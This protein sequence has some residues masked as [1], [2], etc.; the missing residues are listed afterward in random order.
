MITGLFIEKLILYLGTKDHTVEWP[1]TPSNT[2]FEWRFS[3]CSSLSMIS[4]PT[5]QKS[6]RLY[7][8]GKGLVT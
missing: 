8:Y 6:G 2:E 3:F 5:E 7:Y 1:L 4:P